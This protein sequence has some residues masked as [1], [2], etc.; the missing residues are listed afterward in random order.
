VKIAELIED[1]NRNNDT[2]RPYVETSLEESAK[3][4]N[5]KKKKV[6][7]LLVIAGLLLTIMLV[8]CIIPFEATVITIFGIALPLIGS[9][10]FL[11]AAI[12]AACD[13]TR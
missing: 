12:M 11:F 6:I 5:R 4:Y 9:F 7:I 13:N 10:I 2:L 3:I 8:C 1:Y